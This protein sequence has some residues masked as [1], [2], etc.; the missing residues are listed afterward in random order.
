MRHPEDVRVDRE[1]RLGKGDRHHDVRGFAA[2]AGKRLERVAFAWDFTGVLG[3]EPARCPDQILRFHAKEAARLDD[4]FDVGELRSRQRR[5]VG[6]LRK[7]RRR[8]QVDPRVRA[9]R[10]ENYRDEEL[11]RV[12]ILERRDG[13]RIGPLQDRELFVGDGAADFAARKRDRH[14]A[15]FA[16]RR[17]RLFRRASK[18]ASCPS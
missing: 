4:A 8:D 16:P 7:E 12:R 15:L 14:L 1:G 5:R 11:E 9:L 6:I 17:A 18:R 13:V 10:A 3:D 2:D